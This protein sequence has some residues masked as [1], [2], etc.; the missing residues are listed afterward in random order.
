MILGSPP[1]KAVILH[2]ATGGEHHV[3]T[4][5]LLMNEP[6]DDGLASGWYWTPVPANAGAEDLAASLRWHTA[7]ARQQGPFRD[8]GAALRG[9][10]RCTPERTATAILLRQAADAVLTGETEA[11]P[12]H[13][14][15]WIESHEMLAAARG[16][17]PPPP[18]VGPDPAAGP[19]RKP[20][21]AAAML[22][23]AEAGE[24]SA[25]DETEEGPSADGSGPLPA[26]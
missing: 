10:E 3:A 12:A 17:E 6:G 15:D 9:A 4:A 7:V 21:T 23:N 2:E 8:A 26:A 14:A 20:T 13:I 18:P 16:G 5:L 22:R 24:R 25:A 1:E 19:H 11:D